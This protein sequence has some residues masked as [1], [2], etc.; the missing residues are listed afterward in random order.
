MLG[1]RW[2]FWIAVPLGLIGFTSGSILL[3]KTAVAKSRATR[4]FDWVGA[5]LLTFVVFLVSRLDL[6]P[7]HKGVFSAIACAAGILVKLFICHERCSVSPLIDPDLFQSKAFGGGL[8]AVSCFYAFL[9]STFFLLSFAFVHGLGEA[10]V[11]AGWHLAIIPISLGLVAP[12]SGILCSRKSLA[13]LTTTGM[14]L[15]LFAT[16]LLFFWLRGQC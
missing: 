16:M 6:W 9:Y 10:E 11:A 12:I 1:W 7:G 8:A 2:A 5:I 15:C 14:G 3:T 4:R 13:F